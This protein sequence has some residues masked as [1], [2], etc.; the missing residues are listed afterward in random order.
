[1]NR[2]AYDAMTLGPHDIGL[3]LAVLRQRMAEASFPVLSANA[4]VAATGELLAHPYVIRKFAAHRVAVVGLSEPFSTS[5]IQV[6]DP[7]AALRHSLGELSG[8]VDAV[9]VL[10]H[11][12]RVANIRMANE[13]PG[14]TLIIE[15][16]TGARDTLWRSDSTGAVVVHADEPMPGEAGR[17]LG[18]VT[19][20]FGT[21]NSDPDIT[22]YRL[23]LDETIQENPEIQNWLMT[24]SLP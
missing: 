5:E 19:I 16:G 20:T 13:V 9:I 22:W 23:V 21:G 18:R 7:E 4:R 8:K 3:G 12:E 6:E 11:V 1:M 10:S 15:G 17:Y 14:I 2:M 24:G